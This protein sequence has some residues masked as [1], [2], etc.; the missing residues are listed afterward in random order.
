MK[1]SIEKKE[2]EKVLRITNRI[3]G[4]RKS[5]ENNIL[6]EVKDNVL[7]VHSH[8]PDVQHIGFSKVLNG[9]DGEVLING[10]TLMHILK[11]TPD[12]SVLHFELENILKIFFEDIY[13]KIPILDTT[14]FTKISESNEKIESFTFSS[15]KLK[16][17]LSKIEFCVD[18]DDES[19]FSGILWDNKGNIANFVASDRNV[20]GLYTE[21]LEDNF[22]DF[23]VIMPRIIYNLL[24]DIEDNEIKIGFYKDEKMI[25]KFSNGFLSL[26]LISGTYPD[27]ASLFEED[28][29]NKLIIN[30]D[31]IK[32]K[33]KA[34]SS[35]DIDIFSLKV[36]DIIEIAG[37]SYSGEEFRANLLGKYEGDDLEIYLQYDKL[38]HIF[39]AIEEN[40]IYIYIY[41]EL[42]RILIK[43]END[44]LKYLVA[45]RS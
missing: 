5:I 39:D 20:L 25:L 22:G 34:M 7:Y 27:Y 36:G 14:V 19:I 2:I 37:S 28:I 42:S 17:I 11:N 32:H 31:E 13:Y 30:K 18:K 40:E 4:K 3:L 45:T 29:P 24:S 41:P 12:F 23:Q 33:L 1:F 9:K 21:L 35:I 26:R 43:S 16:E 15:K 44:S 8:S 10:S 38:R 6:L